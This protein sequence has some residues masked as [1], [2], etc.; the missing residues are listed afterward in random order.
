M[1]GLWGRD[2]G[3]EGEKGGRGREGGREGRGRKGGKERREGKEGREGGREGRG[4]KGG[5]EGGKG[6][7]GRGVHAG[8]EGEEEKEVLRKRIAVT[9]LG[10]VR[11]LRF[12]Y[13]KVRVCVK[14]LPLKEIVY[15]LPP[16][17]SGGGSYVYISIL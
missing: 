14:V 1:D 2:G 3:R 10:S 6:G 4:R 16:G 13:T 15:M 8:G 9:T 5:R 11:S 7:G 17:F 12:V